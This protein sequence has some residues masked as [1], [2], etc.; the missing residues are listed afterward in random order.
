MTQIWKIT[1]QE[2]RYEEEPKKESEKKTVRESVVL[3]TQEEQAIEGKDK[4]SG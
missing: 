2:L 4:E 3:Q 1:L